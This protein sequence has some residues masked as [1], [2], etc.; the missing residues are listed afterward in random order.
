MFNRTTMFSGS[1]Y[2]VRVGLIILMMVVA[3]WSPMQLHAT[4]TAATRYVATDGVDSG[5][6]TS[7]SAV[8]KSL[9]YTVNQASSG[10]EIFVA[11]GTYRYNT[12]LDEC[13]FSVTQAVLCMVNKN[14]RIVGGFSR[15]NWA[16]PFPSANPSIIDGQNAYRGVSV[17]S[18]NGV[19]RLLMDN[20]IIQSGRAM[21][22]SSGIDFRTYGPGGGM[23]ATAS[24]VA[25]DNVVFRNNVANGGNLGTGYGGGGIGGGLVIRSSPP[26]AVST[27][28]NVTFDN[29]IAQGGIGPERGGVA[30]GGGLFVDNATVTG[31]NLLFTNNKAF[32]GNSGG[33]GTSNNLQSDALGGGVAF[34][35]NTNVTFS[36]ITVQNNR[37]KGGDAATKGGNCF[38]GGV[39][40][41]NNTTVTLNRANI[42]N[43]VA[44]G[45]TATSPGGG[46]GG[47]IATYEAN[48]TINQAFITDNLSEGGVSSNNSQKGGSGGGGASFI[49]ADAVH[50]VSLV[51]SL[52]V[53]N[54]AR[55]GGNGTD[56]GM[57]GAGLGI[58]GINVTL[59]H[60]TIAQNTFG[61]GF[62]LGQGLYVFSNANGRDSNVTM[63]HSIVANH[64][65]STNTAAI[66]VSQENTI[67]FNRALLANN[68][69]NTNQDNVPFPAGTFNGLGTI[70]TAASA[71][72][73]TPNNY[74][75]AD[76]SPAINQAIG[77]TTTIDLDGIQRPRGAATD[78]GAYEHILF[79]D[80]VYIPLVAKNF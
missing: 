75:L 56:P 41:E 34:G 76:S 42:N 70:L 10:D 8:C 19:S 17:V 72:F 55:L 16:V 25:L 78:L 79:T 23:D 28:N 66:H 40:A 59:T 65:N 58:Q 52:I 69:K 61:A 18:F 11:G 64:T 6:C 4:P 29:N 77:S 43:N 44:L 53:R 12:S 54:Q 32:G 35:G 57:G 20:F 62:V 48:G 51:N 22:D 30:Q 15:N 1:N 38:G 7:T 13:S 33:N 60:V 26:G 9:Q 37:C 3:V 49:G 5:S 71:G 24:S 27:L 14:L 45:G 73:R 80:F 46:F 47:G 21:G 31:N 67:T 39:Y 2:Y 50:Q 63:N 74:H 68:T 36:N